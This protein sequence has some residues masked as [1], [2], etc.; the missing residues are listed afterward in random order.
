MPRSGI[1]SDGYLDWHRRHGV[2]L[3]DYQAHGTE[4]EIRNKMKKL[5]P[6]EWKL[7][8]NKLKGK[9]EMGELVQVIPTDYIL[10]GTDDDGLPVFEK[11]VL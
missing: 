10:K 6:N 7:E 8:G 9:T 3:P 1:H 5:L 11:V 2:E 4:E